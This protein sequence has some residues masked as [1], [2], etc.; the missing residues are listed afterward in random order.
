[1]KDTIY[2]IY[3]DI[4]GETPAMFSAPGRV[5]IIGEHTDYNDGFVLPA[6]INKRIYFAIA[7]NKSKRCSI[8]AYNL[9]QKIECSLPLTTDKGDDV[10]WLIYLIG[11][12]D[13]IKKI[14]P[15]NP[16]GFNLVFG[17][18]LPV[19][20]GM[21]SSAALETGFATSLN[22][23]F[24]VQLTQ[25][26]IIQLSQKAEHNYVGLQCGIMDQY[27]AVRGRKG[28]AL[29][30]DCRT[31]KHDYYPLNLSD[32]RLVLCNSMVKHELAS[33]EY[34]TRH[35]E[36]EMGVKIIKSVYPR[37]KKLRD[38]TL[39]MLEENR[40]LFSQNVYKR[41]V[42]VV[43][44]NMRV[45]D[46]CERLLNNNLPGLGENLYSGHQ[47]LKNLYEVSCPEID[48]LVDLTKQNRDVLGARLVGGG[49]GGCT[50]NIVGKD[51][52]KDF[53]NTMSDEYFKKFGTRPDFYTV[54]TDD[55]IMSY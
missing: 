17:G 48:Y 40:D 43:N 35:K 4:Y 46:S 1:M 47:G 13:E 33:S 45:Q 49:F 36:C 21:S 10:S 39:T 30:L 9:N 32:Y 26:E 34:N 11:V 31:L 22:T 15:F 41:C 16:G 42:Y 20:A 6:A 7:K 44:E 51:K 5:N 23:I 38:V 8:F 24:D 50:I 3:R 18:D 29:L 12:I 53:R 28:K 55:G 27:T 14:K 19:G 37:V 25:D 52:I 54:E 2:R